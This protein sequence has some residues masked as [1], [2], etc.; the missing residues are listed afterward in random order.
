MNISTNLHNL[1]HLDINAELVTSSSWHLDIK[2]KLVTNNTSGINKKIKVNAKKLE[3][4]TIFK[5]PGSVVTDK[6]SKP[7]KLSTIE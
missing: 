2:T 4:V 7:E 3:T 1:R 5:Y 6:G